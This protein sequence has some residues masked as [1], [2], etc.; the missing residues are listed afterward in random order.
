MRVFFYISGHGFGHASRDI[1]L[2]RA[3]TRRRP[4]LSVIVRTTVAP[5]LFA[6]APAA[7]DVRPLETD[8]GLVQIDS[9]RLDEQA[10]VA[11]ARRFYANF[12][13]RVTQ[14]AAELRAAGADLVLGDIPPLAF[15]A[16]K[17]A[18]IP[19]IAIGNFT[20]DWIYDAYPSFE[21][22]APDVV[23]TIREAY[24]QAGRALRLP[25][26]G[27]FAAM[28]AVTTDVP[29]IARRS[30]RDRA[31][32]RRRLG[33]TDNRPLVLTSFGAYG[34]AI[35]RDL[36]TQSTS[37][38]AVS[39]E[40]HPPHGLS[41]QDVVAAAD[42]VISKPGYGIVSECIANDTTL[43][44]TSRGRFA[45]YDV[46][47]AEMPRVLRCRFLSQGDLLGG[48]WDEAIAAVLAQ[49]DPPER[50]RVDGADVIADAIMGASASPGA[51]W[52]LVG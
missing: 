48:R 3:L 45:E 27:G 20:W 38:T 9:L 30:L 1:E 26:H 49:P 51:G 34:A 50:W 37:F 18:G 43:V 22:D 13:Q 42:V 24:A 11:E 36:V 28:A 21:R 39:F 6:T 23:P 47:V 46:F 25:F 41:Y 44:Y 17:R 40:T 29:L 2:I 16:A 32:T 19:S 12:D 4:D 31:D 15:A 52:P 33:V 5:W 8:T 7:V 35:P 14:E 10:S